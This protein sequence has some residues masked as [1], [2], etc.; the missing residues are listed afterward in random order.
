MKESFRRW[1]TFILENPARVNYAVITDLTNW[2]GVISEDD[3]YSVIAWSSQVRI[4]NNV[5]AAKLGRLAWIG[6]AGAG[7][8]RLTDIFNAIRPGQAFHTASAQEAWE[9]VMPD[10]SMPVNA[11]NF[12]RKGKLF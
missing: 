1:Q 4:E 3:V 6:R 8:N 10:I 2:S 12:F 7:L 11:K 5:P 9:L